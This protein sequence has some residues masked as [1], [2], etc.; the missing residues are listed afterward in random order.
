MSANSSRPLISVTYST[1]PALSRFLPFILNS[2]NTQLPLRNLHWKTLSRPTIRTVQEC[3]VR[4][5]GLIDAQSKGY[6]SDWIAPSEIEYGSLLSQSPLIH[7]AFV[8]CEDSETYKTSIRPHIN[9]WL[10]SL[11]VIPHAQKIIALVSVPPPAGHKPSESKGGVFSNIRNAGAGIPN[12][13]VFNKIK[14]DFEVSTKEQVAANVSTRTRCIALS[15][16]STA[17]QTNVPAVLP[18][19]TLFVDLLQALKELTLSALD[20]IVAEREQIVRQSESYMHSPPSGESWSFSKYFLLKECLACSFENMGLSEDALKIYDELEESLA[21]IMRENLAWIGRPGTDGLESNEP[22][23][24]P[25]A[26]RETTSRQRQQERERIYNGTFSIFEFRQSEMILAQHPVKPAAL[27]QDLIKRAVAFIGTMA[28]TTPNDTCILQ[29][30]DPSLIEAWIYDASCAVDDASIELSQRGAQTQ[31]EAQA[32]TFTILNRA[33]TEL[34]N[35]AVLQL[36]RTGVTKGFLPSAPPFAMSNKLMPQQDSVLFDRPDASPAMTDVVDTKANKTPAA[37]HSLRPLTIASRDNNVFQ[38]LYESA[39]DR[40]RQAEIGSG[41]VRG[42]QALDEK[43]AANAYHQGKWQV[44]YNKYLD[45]SQ[46]YKADEARMQGSS[47]T[48]WPSLRLCA[49]S[50]ALECHL[51]MELPVNR[52]FTLLG[53]EYLR[54]YTDA[55]EG[56]QQEERSERGK[57]TIVKIVQSWDDF[58]ADSETSEMEILEHPILHIAL[59]DNQARPIDNE[60]GACCNLQIRNLLPVDIPVSSISICFSGTMVEQLWFTASATVLK[61]GSNDVDVTCLMPITG[62]LC[63]DSG[64]LSH[65]NLCFEYSWTDPSDRETRLLYVPQN[66][67]SLQA[68]VRVAR[69]IS[70]LAEPYFEVA[71]RSGRNEVRNAV[72]VLSSSRNDVRLRVHATKNESATVDIIA[73]RQDIRILTMRQDTELILLVPYACPV[74]LDMLDVRISL[75]YETKDRSDLRRALREFRLLDLALPIAVNVQDFFRSNC[76]ISKFTVSSATQKFIRI[77]SAELS[78]TGTDYKIQSFNPKT[79]ASYVTVDRPVPYLF[80]MEKVAKSAADSISSAA[81]PRLV[82]T[83]TLVNEELE[84]IIRDV[85][86]TKSR[87]ADDPLAVQQV[88]GHIINSCLKDDWVARYVKSGDLRIRLPEES[89]PKEFEVEIVRLQPLLQEMKWPIQKARQRTLTVPVEIPP[90]Q[91]IISSYVTFPS[92]EQ[93]FSIGQPL[94]AQISMTSS[95]SWADGPIADDLQMIYDIIVDKDNWLV[96]GT[97]RGTFQVTSSQKSLVVNVTLIPLRHGLLPYPSVICHPLPATS[98]TSTTTQTEIQADAP[99]FYENHQLDAASRVMIYPT[100][101]RHMLMQVVREVSELTES[102]EHVVV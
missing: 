63:M 66:P 14:A 99:V 86:Q 5:I 102:G 19:P 85:I 94:R 2:L 6:A 3:D 12:S 38:S 70:L 69:D 98:P 42:T 35:L 49:L 23:I 72:L 33:R 79:Q 100:P 30:A 88:T 16:P 22:L 34:L 24:D 57:S 55:I 91:V 93:Q 67:T 48:K 84:D 95:H 18:D 64:K 77:V 4:F 9:T 75:D 15:L 53:F 73:T 26:D 62:L 82:L 46:Q 96:S 45:L 76:L 87:Y 8:E 68:D 52:T 56:E 80:K 50:R 97:K 78:E 17:N 40:A 43:V 27:A 65:D 37:E 92:T 20:S 41:R 81:V 60:D 90:M 28:R 54:V 13:A 1:T 32:D 36:D 51:N 44:A 71:I 101:V 21:L 31:K 61:P 39:I 74:R 11:P 25:H 7:I 47:L 58:K 89:L 10:S 59:A 83:Y 29:T